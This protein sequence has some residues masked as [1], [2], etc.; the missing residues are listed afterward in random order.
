MLG[1]VRAAVGIRPPPTLLEA[2]LPGIY[3]HC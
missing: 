1:G 2:G 3:E